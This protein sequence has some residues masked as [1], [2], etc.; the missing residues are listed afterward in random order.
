MSDLLKIGGESALDASP[1]YPIDNPVSQP[2]KAMS[3]VLADALDVPPHAIIPFE[4][5]IKRVRRSPPSVT[6]NPA[7]G[8]ILSTERVQGHCNIIAKDR[9]VSPE[10]TRLYIAVWK[11]M[12]FLHR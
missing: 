2:W 4:T 11:R 6:K 12:G 9:P 5:W 1:V 7:G 3:P 10:V 8:L